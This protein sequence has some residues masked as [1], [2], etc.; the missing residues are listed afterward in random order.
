MSFS[1]DLV[2]FARLV[3]QRERD[4]FVRTTQEVARSVVEG[5]EV[6]G[7]PGSPVDTGALRGSWVGE[8]V[9]DHEWHLTTN[10][11]Y[12]P[13]VEDNVGNVT[14]KVGGPHGV[15]LTIAGFE[16]IVEAVTDEVVR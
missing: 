15:K 5:S 7:A 16:R 2:A 12:A 14:F 11:E 6:T 10:V 1:Q 8:F 3:E 9:S 13:F 4:V